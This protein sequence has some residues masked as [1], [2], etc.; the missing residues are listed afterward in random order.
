MKT[1]PYISLTGPRGERE[2]GMFPHPVPVYLSGEDFFPF[3]SPRGDNHP[4]P[5]NGGIPR[6]DSGIGAYCHL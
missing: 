5:L 3:T 4:H 1:S 2:W 6:G